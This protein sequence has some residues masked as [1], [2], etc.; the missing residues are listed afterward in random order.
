MKKSICILLL[1]IF[2]LTLS[3]TASAHS[4]RTD[5]YGG[6]NDNINGGYHYHHG[7]PAHDHP[8]GVCPYE[9]ESSTAESREKEPLNFSQILNRIQ[10]FFKLLLSSFIL[11]FIFA[12]MISHFCAFAFRK[13]SKKVE[14]LQK[15]LNNNYTTKVLYVLTC[16]FS[17][18][19]FI[20]FHFLLY[21]SK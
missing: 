19:L 17:I 12:G 7:Y 16:V 13:L 14:K 2:I 4:G 5:A 20:L 21:S 11:G 8:G 3:V 18:F 6:H 10:D 15:Y 1:S 9:S